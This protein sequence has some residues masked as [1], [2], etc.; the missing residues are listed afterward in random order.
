MAKDGGGGLQA[1]ESA[2]TRESDTERTAR[3]R[4]ATAE[5][6]SMEMDTT[7]EPDIEPGLSNVAGNNDEAIQIYKACQV[8]GY[9]ASIM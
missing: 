3:G 8:G 5:E 2:A 7:A 6:G 4:A 9:K 1:K